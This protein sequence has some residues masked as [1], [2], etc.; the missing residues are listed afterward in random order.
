MS[1]KMEKGGLSTIGE[2]SNEW[3]TFE[4]LQTMRDEHGPETTTNHD[5]SSRA[6]AG[7]G[8]VTS[9]AV[10]HNAFRHNLG[11]TL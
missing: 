9:I 5:H 11:I 6:P 2:T 1:G 7:E 4:H 8:N 10:S 3:S